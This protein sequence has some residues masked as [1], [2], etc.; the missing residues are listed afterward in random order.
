MQKNNVNE[1]KITL[2]REMLIQIVDIFNKM[3]AKAY[4]IDFSM[5]DLPS[6]EKFESLVERLS[7]CAS[8]QAAIITVSFNFIEWVTF[9]NYAL[10]SVDIPLAPDED[11]VMTWLI[12]TNRNLSELT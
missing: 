1:Y 3:I 6:F 4:L 8:T 5:M 11:K 2:Q 10:H 7:S 12:N 9:K